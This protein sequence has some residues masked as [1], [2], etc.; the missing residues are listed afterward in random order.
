MSTTED[1]SK[2]PGG[3]RDLSVPVGRSVGRT[4]SQ[5]LTVSQSVSQSVSRSINRTPPS[6]PFLGEEADFI[7]LNMT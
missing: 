1:N 3:A 7:L 2:P 6:P 4:V 5:S